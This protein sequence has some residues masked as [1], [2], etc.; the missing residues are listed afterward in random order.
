MEQ[1]SYDQEAFDWLES[2]EDGSL[3]LQAEQLLFMIPTPLV[4]AFTT[5]HTPELINLGVGTFTIDELRHD[6]DGLD[7]LAKR[8]ETMAD[9]ES[10][11]G[12]QNKQH[13]QRVKLELGVLC[14][15]IR[16]QSVTSLQANKHAA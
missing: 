5:L 10:S 13:V 1:Q 14:N 6:N 12:L 11:F 16:T 4:P 9:H 7:R 2:V 8:F 15:W 3:T